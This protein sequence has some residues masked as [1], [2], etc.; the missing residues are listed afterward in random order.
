MV[1]IT[2]SRAIRAVAA[3][4]AAVGGLAIAAGAAQ[5]ATLTVSKV[6]VPAGDPTAFTFRVQFTAFSFDRPPADFQPPGEFTL[7]GGQ[8]RTFTDL[9][10]GFYT[11]TELTPAGWQVA[12]IAC[13]PPDPQPEDDAVVDLGAGS[14]RLEIS[15]TESKA[16]TFTDRRQVAPTPP[17]A[18][19][20][21]PGVAPAPPTPPPPAAV[22]RGERRQAPTA[23]LSAPKGCV[24]RR[25]TV[26]VTGGPI[27]SVTFLLNGRKV[28]TLRA[29]PG[30]R[31]FAVRLPASSPIGRVVAR[32]R[33]TSRATRRTRTL[34][35]RVPRCAR[36]A[37]TPRFT[38]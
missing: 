11:I 19:P 34:R 6:T 32:V 36:R 37:V 14:A 31:R 33:F 21:A 16:C 29:R 12:A 28:R 35:V 25:Y 22:V 20:P 8:S 3:T 13:G 17:A 9:H 38:G 30:Q 18:A 1:P 5:A 23:R 15:R 4:L 26:A 2:L 24:S 10:K 27:R 7:T